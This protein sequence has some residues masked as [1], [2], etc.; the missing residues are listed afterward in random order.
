MNKLNKGQA[1]NVHPKAKNIHPVKF[2]KNFNKIINKKIKKENLFKK[3]NCE[4]DFWTLDNTVFDD[5]LNVL[6]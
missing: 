4:W 2:L 1:K 5:F 3:K 6:R